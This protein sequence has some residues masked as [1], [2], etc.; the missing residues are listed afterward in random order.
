MQFD[1]VALRS[2]RQPHPFTIGG[3]QDRVNSHPTLVSNRHQHR[4]LFSWLFGENDAVG[5]AQIRCSL[6]LGTW[7]TWLSGCGAVRW[8]AVIS[9]RKRRFA[10]IPD[11]GVMPEQSAPATLMIISSRAPDSENLVRR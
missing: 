5:V 10:S 7:P 11:V 8:R 6:W 3:Q 4:G 1:C 9:L 2:D